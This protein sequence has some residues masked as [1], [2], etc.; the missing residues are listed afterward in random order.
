[1]GDEGR[2]SRNGDREGVSL[3]EGMVGRGA[4]A[5]RE[6]CLDFGLGDGRVKVK[7]GEESVEE[8]GVGSGWG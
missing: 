6:S 1:V 3:S 8:L 2:W 7:D 5:S 4:S